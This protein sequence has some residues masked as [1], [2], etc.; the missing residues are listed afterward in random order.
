MATS[1]GEA[2]VGVVAV[3]TLPI[4]ILTALFLG[5]FEAA[6][7]FV[8]GW[9][10]LVP[11]LGILAEGFGSSPGADAS[12]AIDA[13]VEQRVADAIATAGLDG[14]A[15]GARDEDPVEALRERYAR[16]EI[17]D[18]EF[19]RTL[20][21]LIATEDVEVPDGVTLADVDLDRESEATDEDVAF[22][23]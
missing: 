5:P 2:L 20:E 10:L 8:V 12:D 22:E 19:E 11:V 23:R 14:D 16:G 4:G 1:P 21:R 15:D 7:V 6:V 18:A 3:A 17:D 13:A 9:L